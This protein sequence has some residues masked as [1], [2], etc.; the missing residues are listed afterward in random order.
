M[1]EQFEKFSEK[2]RNINSQLTLTQKLSIIAVFVASFGIITAVALRSSSVDYVFLMSELSRS[3]SSEIVEILKK[4]GV[5]YKLE[6]DGRSIL[7][8]SSQVMEIRLKLAGMGLPEGDAVGYELFD[9]QDVTTLTQFTEHVSMIR[10]IQGELARTITHLEPVEYARVHIVMPEESMFKEDQKEPSASIMV[11]LKRGKYLSR[12][13]IEAVTHMISHAVK[14]LKRENVSIVDNNGKVLYAEDESMKDVSEHKLNFKKKVEKNFEENILRVITP[15]VGQGNLRVSVSTRMNFDKS[16]R[17]EELFDPR[18]TAVRSE[19]TMKKSTENTKGAAGGVVGAEANLPGR[20]GEAVNE[21]DVESSDMKKAT[22]NYEVNRTI[23]HVV[24]NIG[25]IEKISA[26]VIL[27]GVKTTGDDGEVKEIPMSDERVA[28]IEK[29]V[30]TAIGFDEERGDKISVQSIPFV[31]E[32]P[33]ITTPPL[34]RELLDY[35]FRYHI[36]EWLVV[37]LIL[38]FV[39]RPLFK[40]LRDISPVRATPEGVMVG[41]DEEEGLSDSQKRK[42]ELE[43]ESGKNGFEAK[44]GLTEDEIDEINREVEQKMGITMSREQIMAISFARK[45][46]DIAYKIIKKWLKSEG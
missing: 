33:A 20:A 12:N 13:N 1:K 16:R 41:G 43:R 23:K 46:P 15:V 6:Q 31:A 26:S 24:E 27:G 11:K 10:A 18:Q 29:M 2:F 45:N 32:K 30:K 34:Y 36:F 42:R 28:N 40:T 8:P 17:E 37:L 25:K 39:V 7:V 19:T 14:G 38:L 35:A 3:D 44:G 5:P 4:D 9:N 22:V 21:Q